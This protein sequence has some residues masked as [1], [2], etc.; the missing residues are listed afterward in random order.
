MPEARTALRLCLRQLREG[1]R[2]SILAFDDQIETFSSQS[3]PFTQATLE[4]A[5]AWLETID[6]RG[7]TELLGPMKEAA[8]IAP[9]GV[10]VLITDGEVGNEDEILAAFMAAQTCA[11][12]Y[13]F[14]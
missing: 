3:V 7:G 10:I 5:D 6:A 14:G 1:D 8:R 12:V 2:F 11:R 13:S 4:R 9:S